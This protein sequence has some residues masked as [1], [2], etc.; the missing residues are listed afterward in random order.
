MIDALTSWYGRG[1]WISIYELVGG[2]IIFACLWF[3]VVA[4]NRARPQR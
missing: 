3:V 1:G 2:A 4:A